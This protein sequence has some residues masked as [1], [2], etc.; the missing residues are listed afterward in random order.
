[1]RGTIHVTVERAGMDRLGDAREVFLD[2]PLYERYFSAEGKLESLLTTAIE[3]R[4]LWLAVDSRGQ[5]VGAMWVEPAGFFGAFPYLALLGVRKDFR[6]MGVGHTLLS[7]YEG[8]ARALGY[9][10]ISLL[11]SHF[12]PRAKALYQSLGFR[13]VGYVPDAILPGID[14]NIMV[15]SL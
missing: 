2:S 8:V 9:R 14:E 1:M 5:A 13:K 3:R 15:K 4:E 10:K 6:G 11:V 7:V 12:N